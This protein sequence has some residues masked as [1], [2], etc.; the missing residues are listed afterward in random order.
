MAHDTPPSLRQKKRRRVDLGNVLRSYCLVVVESVP[1]RVV[2]HSDHLCGRDES[3]ITVHKITSSLIEP[4]CP[5]GST[6]RVKTQKREGEIGA[7]HLPVPD[8]PDNSLGILKKRIK[9][10]I[11]QRAYAPRHLHR[12]EEKR[13]QHDARN[14]MR[15][16]VSRGHQIN[17]GL[18]GVDTGRCNPLFGRRTAKKPVLFTQLLIKKLMKR[19]EKV[20]LLI[21]DEKRTLLSS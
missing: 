14:V 8:P 19:R 1:L 21:K 13:I 16:S 2:L 10:S 11:R 17:R 7:H 5:T 9:R 6:V 20:D 3:I 15:E 4:S 12:S 18:V